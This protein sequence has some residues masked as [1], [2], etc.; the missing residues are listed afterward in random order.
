VAALIR[1]GADVNARN[2]HGTTPLLESAS[3]Q[4]PLVI[5]LLAEAGADMESSDERG[6]ALQSALS[7]GC[8][9][10]VEELVKQ[11][12]NVNA[13]PNPQPD[14][15]WVI[16]TEDEWPLLV[17]DTV[18]TRPLYLAVCGWSP[19]VV[20]FLLDHGA[21]INALSFGW[22][23]LHAAVVKPDRRMVELLLRRGADPHVRSDVHSV[24]GVEYNHRTPMDLLDGFR[25]SAQHLREALHA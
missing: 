18:G 14:L 8:R 5:R 7:Q 24:V 3:Q 19:E 11:G 12:A 21:E 4:N 13:E 1:H 15:G 9:D 25:R 2:R 17:G 10:V 20:E 23:A 6:T 22:S 16:Y